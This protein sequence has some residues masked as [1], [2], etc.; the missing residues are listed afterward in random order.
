MLNITAQEISPMWG[1]PNFIAES[2]VLII[3][4]KKKKRKKKNEIK[5]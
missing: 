4:S 5:K 1:L 2:L 3:K